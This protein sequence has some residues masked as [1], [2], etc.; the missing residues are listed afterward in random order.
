MLGQA[1]L[2]TE[3]AGTIMVSTVSLIFA[4]G[5]RLVARRQPIHG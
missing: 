2:K 4:A 1:G 5:F 3:Q